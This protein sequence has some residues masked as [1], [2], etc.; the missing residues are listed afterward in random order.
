MET[1]AGKYITVPLSCQITVICRKG[2]FL[3]VVGTYEYMHTCRSV[4]VCCIAFRSLVS[5]LARLE[6]GCE[7]L[8]VQR[9][10]SE[11]VSQFTAGQLV[12]PRAGGVAGGRSSGGTGHRRPRWVVSGSQWEQPNAGPSTPAALLTYLGPAHRPRL[13]LL[14]SSIFRAWL[15]IPS[16]V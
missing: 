14:D 15:D 5:P 4:R 7:L 9:P 6:S 12:S 2:T 3:F 16:P 13:E 1:A 11:Q 10:V 8:N